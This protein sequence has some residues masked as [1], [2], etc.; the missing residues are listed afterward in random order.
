MSTNI[1]QVISQLLMLLPVYYCISIYTCLAH[2]I[3]EYL[4]TNVKNLHN[5]IMIF[6][7]AKAIFKIYKIKETCHILTC[8]MHTIIVYQMINTWRSYSKYLFKSICSEAC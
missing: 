5:I 1:Y 4:E 3:R 2:A 6:A 7:C 8:V